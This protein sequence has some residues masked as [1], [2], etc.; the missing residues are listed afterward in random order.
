MPQPTTPPFEARRRAQ[1]ARRRRS[2]RT[3][4]SVAIPAV[5]TGLALLVLWLGIGRP[6]SP[7]GGAG[8]DVPALGPGARPPDIPIASAGQVQLRLPVDPAKVT[9]IAFRPADDTGALSL[10]P[11]GPLPWEDLGGAGDRRAGVDVGARA[12]TLVYSPV[13]G[14]IIAIVPFV[15][16][17]RVLGSQYAIKPSSNLGVVV[18]VSHVEPSVGQPKRGVGDN[19]RAGTTV[20]GQVPD[21]SVLVRQPIARFTADEGNHVAIIVVRLADG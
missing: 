13:D 1:A 14:R 2:R 12:G 3:A 10:T 8:P 9:A 4:V 6:S 11:S 21:A 16:R 17:G 19:V 18:L 7:E 15:L 20:L 5:I